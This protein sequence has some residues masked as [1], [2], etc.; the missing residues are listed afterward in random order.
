[1]KRCLYRKYWRF[2]V[3]WR[4]IVAPMGRRPLVFS[5]V[6]SISVSN[7]YRGRCLRLLS[8]RTKIFR[9]PHLVGSVEGVNIFFSIS[10]YIYY[11]TSGKHQ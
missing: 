6:R 10:I 8:L 1:M 3:P 7:L 9:L 11:S 2:S 4:P 5:C